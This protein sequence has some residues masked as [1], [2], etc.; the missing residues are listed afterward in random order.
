[1]RERLEQYVPNLHSKCY[2]SQWTSRLKTSRPYR[3]PSLQVHQPALLVMPPNRIP[4]LKARMMPEARAQTTRTSQFSCHK[5]LHRRR[6]RTRSFLP[7]LP[8]P[9][10]EPN[11]SPTK[12]NLSNLSK[13]VGQNVQRNHL[14]PVPHLS[15]HICLAKSSRRPPTAIPCGIKCTSV[16]SIDKSFEYL[17]QDHQVLPPRSEPRPTVTKRRRRNL[18]NIERNVG[19]ENPAHQP[20]LDPL[21]DPSSSA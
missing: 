8:A 15:P 16:L 10:S 11:P 1:M 21:I 18:E 4:P 14:H 12:A 5:Y 2:P 9:M 20:K 13:K 3:R 17:D 7:N 6:Q 19:L